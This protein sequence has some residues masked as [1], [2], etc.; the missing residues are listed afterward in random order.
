MNRAL[1]ISQVCWN[2]ALMPENSRDETLAEMQPS[3]NMDDDEFR[4]FRRSFVEPMI[5]R[6]KEKFPGM[7]QRR[8]I[9]S[10]ERVFTRICG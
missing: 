2:L 5:Q 9:I 1:M 3:L 4:A 8:S 7:H 10:A 6:H